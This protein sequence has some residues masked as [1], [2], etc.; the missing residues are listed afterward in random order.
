ML[1][2]SN[3]SLPMMD[4]SSES[5]SRPVEGVDVWLI[6]INSSPA[7]AER[8]LPMFAENLI[9]VAIDPAVFFPEAAS[10]Q[11][12]P[13]AEATLTTSPSSLPSESCE[14]TGGVYIEDFVT[15]HY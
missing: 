9:K 1:T 12:A 10:D 15:L 3:P 8:L 11:E 6:E 13:H 4:L 7:V 14:G 2:E 5:L